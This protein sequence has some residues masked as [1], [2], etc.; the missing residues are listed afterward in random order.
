[1]LLFISPSSVVAPLQSQYI[2]KEF[3]LYSVTS[4]NTSNRRDK[5]RKYSRKES[6]T[7]K[8]KET[9]FVHGSF[10]IICVSKITR[11]SVREMLLS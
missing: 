1:M 7:R 11:N 3:L 8:V 5:S 9:H 10:C 4:I 2:R 6:G